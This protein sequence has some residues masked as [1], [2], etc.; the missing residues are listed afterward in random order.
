MSSIPFI[1]VQ[2]EIVVESYYRR[3][4]MTVEC[5][6]RPGESAE[7]A[8]YLRDTF[9]PEEIEIDDCF[10]MLARI[11]VVNLWMPGSARGALPNYT[12]SALPILR[13]HAHDRIDY[14]DRHGLRRAVALWLQS[15][16]TG[17]PTEESELEKMLTDSGLY[18]KLKTA[19]VR[20]CGR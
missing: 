3:T 10:F 12:A 16:R 13:Q 5:F 18:A 20:E 14:L 15:I 19:F 2:P 7:E 8:V 6:A 17:P 9:L 11:S 1:Q 4:F